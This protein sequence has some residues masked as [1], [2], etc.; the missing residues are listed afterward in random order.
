MSLFEINQQLIS[1]FNDFT[2]EDWVEAV[3]KIDKWHDEI[4][5]D[6]YMMLCKEISYYTVFINGDYSHSSLGEM[7]REC[8]AFVGN[9]LTIDYSNKE[10]LDIWI[11]INEETQ[12]LHLFNYTRG[13]VDFKG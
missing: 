9:V 3:E 11:R 4:K 6:Y 12:C 13:V 1:Q 5:S 2:N 7:V 10:C 8:L